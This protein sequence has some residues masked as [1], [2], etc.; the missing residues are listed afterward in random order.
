MSAALRTPCIL[1]DKTKLLL[2]IT[3]MQ[4]VASS[5]RVSLRP[6]VKTHKSNAIATLQCT[7]GA[8]GLSAAKISEAIEFFSLNTPITITSPLIDPDKISHVISSA[9]NN[10]VALTL[11]IDSMESFIAL[12]AAIS[13][14]KNY[15]KDLLDVMVKIDTGLHRCGIEE[16]N[17]DAVIAPILRKLNDHDIRLSGILSHAG[18]AYGASTVDEIRNIAEDER[19]TMVRVKHRI[20][21][22]FPQLG[23]VK[24][25]VGCS[26]TELARED[27]T[28]IDEIRPGNYALSD[29]TSIR[30]GLVNIGSVAMTVASRVI[31]QNSRYWIIDAGSKMLSSD[32]GPHGTAGSGFGLAFL[33]RDFKSVASVSSGLSVT[34]L[35][36][37]HGWVEKPKNAP[38][39]PTGTMMTIVPN[40]SCAV[41]NLSNYFTM[42]NRDGSFSSTT[43]NARG[44]CL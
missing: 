37:E 2:N 43:I 3:G 20:M 12:E 35:S 9:S 39:I 15:R 5:A 33:Y 42:V 41:M 38:E 21:N 24:V 18:H 36:E 16:S 34:N 17:F 19:L 7:S 10:S 25:S 32:R 23:A 6:H 22:D 44:C 4:K 8:N 29:L 30:K 11:T 31:S 1:V 26:M 40:H 28:D 13:G 27:F 14:V